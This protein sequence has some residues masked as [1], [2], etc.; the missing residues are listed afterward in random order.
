MKYLVLR[1]RL[2][3]YLQKKEAVGILKTNVFQSRKDDLAEPKKRDGF[4]VLKGQPSPHTSP[5]KAFHAVIAKEPRRLRQS[6]PEYYL[7][8][9]I[10]ALQS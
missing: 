6:R 7:R 8:F 2:S 4:A 9:Q 3:D 5:L 10:A 1:Y